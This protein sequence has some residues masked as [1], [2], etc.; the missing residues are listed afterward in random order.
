MHVPRYYLVSLGVPI[1]L[2]GQLAIPAI[3]A[4]TK[5]SRV[6]TLVVLACFDLIALA[7]FSRAV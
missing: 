4:K 7:L 2:A 6:F 3:A 5:R 1:L